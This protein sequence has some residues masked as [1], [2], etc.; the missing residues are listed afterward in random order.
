MVSSAA[1]EPENPAVAIRWCESWCYIACSNMGGKSTFSL[2][3]QLMTIQF[4]TAKRGKMPI[5]FSTAL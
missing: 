5:S 1:A 4:G 2:L 3:N